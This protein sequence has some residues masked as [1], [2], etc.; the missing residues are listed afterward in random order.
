MAFIEVTVIDCEPPKVCI[1]VDSIKSIK[2]AVRGCA[3]VDFQVDDVGEN[4]Y[5]SVTETYDQVKSLIE[6][7]TYSFISSVPAQA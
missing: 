6:R 3:I 5:W 2:P 1:N 7:A 4:E